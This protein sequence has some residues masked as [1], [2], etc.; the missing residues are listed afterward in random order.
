MIIERAADL[1]YH[2]RL[3][4]AALALDRSARSDA[5][6][7][8]LR[9][10]LAAA[11]GDFPNAERLAR[12]ILRRTRLDPGSAAR[13][14]VT[15][16]SV[17]R[18]TGRHA[19]ARIVD[20]AALSAVRGAEDR[21]HL[22]IGL[23]ADAV[24]LG[25]FAAVDAALRVV[26]GAARQ[27]RIRVRLLWVRS[28]RELLAERPG[29]PPG[30]LA[31]RSIFPNARG[32]RGTPRSRTSSWEPRCSTRRERGRRPPIFETRGAACSG[33]GPSR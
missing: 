30:T 8:W 21:A 16:G 28:E 33:R 17:L 1:A 15:L 3:R 7:M 31:A 27:W 12:R 32:R 22:L 14:S 2:G 24:G 6:A 20:N 10:Y 25:E 5:D 13:A 29:P 23:A 4:E 9:A 11:S 18:Q 26:P 19:E